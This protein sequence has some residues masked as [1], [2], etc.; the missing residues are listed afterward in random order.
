MKPQ[1]CPVFPACSGPLGYHN[2]FLPAA[3]AGIL[4]SGDVQRMRTSFL[5]KWQ[6]PLSPDDSVHSFLVGSSPY[7]SL[8]QSI[9]EIGS[10]EGSR[11]CSALKFEIP[12]GCSLISVGAT[13]G[14]RILKCAESGRDELLRS[15]EKR[16]H[17]TS[18][19]LCFQH[20]SKVIQP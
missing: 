17:L 12:F 8:S 4:C 7:F 16:Y 10:S 15:M 6:H 9:G 11:H 18:F 14:L 19:Q 20:R 13:I 2:P 3:F 5:K 1:H